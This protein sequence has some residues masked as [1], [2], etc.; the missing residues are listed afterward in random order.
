MARPCRDLS[1]TSSAGVWQKIL[2]RGG[3]VLEICVTSCDGPHAVTRKPRTHRLDEYLRGGSGKSCR[4]CSLWLLSALPL[5]PSYISAHVSLQGK[6]GSTLRYRRH[7]ICR[8]LR[9][10]RTEISSLPRSPT[11]G[12]DACGCAHS[13]PG[14]RGG[15]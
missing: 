7:R 9:Y 13:L 6:Y 8:H 11:T 15:F 1:S 5:L 12:R 3:K 14:R 2:R 10:H 4:G